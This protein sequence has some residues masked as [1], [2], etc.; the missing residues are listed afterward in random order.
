MQQVGRDGAVGEFMEMPDLGVERLT[1]AI[2]DRR[3]RGVPYGPTQVSAYSPAG[4]WIVGDNSDYSFEIHYPDGRLVRAHRYWDPVPIEADHADYLRRTTIASARRSEP[5]FNWNGSEI[6]DYKTAYYA[7]YPTRGNRLLVVREGPSHL[8]EGCD[9]TFDLNEGPADDCYRPERV[10][11]MFDLEG[12]YL[13]EVI[14]PQFARLWTP[15]WGDD[16]LLLVV[17]DEIGTVMVKRF[18]FRLPGVAE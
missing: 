1:I 8:V 10:W 15:F 18:R 11:D 6:P 14:R 5:D 4:A 16:L 17:E 2:D 9:P 13:G 3:T 12:N 7:F